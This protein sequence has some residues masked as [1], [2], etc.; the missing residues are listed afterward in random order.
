MHSVLSCVVRSMTDPTAV[1]GLPCLACAYQIFNACRVLQPGDM[2]FLQNHIVVH[3]RSAFTDF[4]VRTNP[5]PSLPSHHSV[6]HS[7]PRD[8]VSLLQPQ[9][10]TFLPSFR[11]AFCS[12][13]TKVAHTMTSFLF[14]AGGGEA[15][16]SAAVV[17]QPTAGVATAGLLR[18]ALWQRGGGG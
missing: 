10:H 1:H 17:A 7:Q 16:T 12:W 5:P 8:S 3:N 18:G 2:Q 4:L 15:Q 6:Q 9:G 11:L 14:Y 13:G